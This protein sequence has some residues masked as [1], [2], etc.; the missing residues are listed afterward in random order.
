MEEL[1]HQAEQQRAQAALAQQL[2]EDAGGWA[3]SAQ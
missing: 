1:H 2:T 3:L